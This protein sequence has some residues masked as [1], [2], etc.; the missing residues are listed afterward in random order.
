MTIG[1]YLKTKR[2]EKGL[3]LRQLAYKIN[4]SHTN[5]ADVEKGVIK[6][7]SSILKILAALNLSIEENEQA[8]QLLVKDTTPQNLQEDILN[9]KRNLI[10][11]DNSNKGDIVVGKN[12]KNFFNTTEDE[13]DLTGLN[14]SEIQSVKNYIA[15]IKSQKLKKK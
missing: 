7:E 3:S 1:E 15:F 4:L 9:L 13:L 12:E 6:K 11:K 8:L 5:V 10:I 14:E 2:Q